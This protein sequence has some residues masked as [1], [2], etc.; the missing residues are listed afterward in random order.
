MGSN[1]TRG[2]VVSVQIPTK[3]ERRE[4]TESS[5]NKSTNKCVNIYEKSNNKSHLDMRDLYNR[6]N[7]LN[8]WIKRIHEELDGSDKTDVLEFLEIMQE[9]DQSILTIIRCISVILQLRK[10]FGKPFSQ[11]TKEDI[12]LLFKWMDE[13]GYMLETHQKFR[14]IL[15]KFYKMVHGNNEYYPDCVKWF[16]VKVGKDKRSQE[17]QLD[18]N[19]Y[20]EEEETKQ[21]IEAAPTVQKKAFLACLYESGSRPEEYLRLTNFDIKIDKDGAIFILRGKTGERRVRIVSFTPLLQQ[22]LDIHP[23]KNEEQFPLWISE[24]TNYKNKPLGFKGA[25]NIIHDALAKANLSNKHARLYLLRH[26]RATHLASWMTESQMCAFFGWQQGTQVVRRYIHLS[27]KDLDKVLLSIGEG[28]QIKREDE[29]QLKTFKCIRCSE[30]LS[31]TQ[32]FCSRCGFTT[33]LSEQYT[34]EMNLEKENVE[35]KLEIASIREEMNQKISILMQS[36]KEILECLKYPER[37]IE[38]SA[39]D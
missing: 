33:N 12:K 29:Y 37:L 34:K 6:K 13:K 5:F 32:K 11:I 10:Q 20:L 1:P 39:N 18:I 31:P 7:R 26:S 17:R 8:H 16:S 35:L 4:V 3:K 38:I 9:K 21:M 15:K 2:S 14:A 27:G 30:T 24:A 22:W 19:E 36:Q 25:E 23:L 28:K